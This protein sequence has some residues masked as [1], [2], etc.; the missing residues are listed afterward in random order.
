MKTIQTDGAPKAIG[1][2]AQA[3]EAG[4]LVFV[5]GQLGLDPATGQ[6]A[7]DFA[8]QA[9]QVFANLGAILKAAG[10]GFG[11]VAKVSVFLKDLNDFAALGE[12][13]AAHFHE[14]YPARETVEVARLPR[15]ARIE[16]S[17][18]A[19]RPDSATKG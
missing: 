1:P 7:P 4:S 18:I 16:I 19:V 8:T 2:Y 14:P 9:R 10:A 13:Y 6:L 3:V 17:L 12:I 15:D 11:D 5:S